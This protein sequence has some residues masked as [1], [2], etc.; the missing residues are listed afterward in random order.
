MRSTGIFF[1]PG[2]FTVN[3]PTK[4]IINLGCW[5]TTLIATVCPRKSYILVPDEG[6]HIL[7]TYRLQE[8]R[9]NY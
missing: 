9:E 1:N 6:F 7:G 3:G 8:L 4:V 2:C 5:A